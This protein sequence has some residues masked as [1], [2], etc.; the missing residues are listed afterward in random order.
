M[1]VR[2]AVDVVAHLDAA[3]ERQRRER[4]L[5]QAGIANGTHLAAADRA[6][7]IDAIVAQ[8]ARKRGHG[9]TPD[10]VVRCEQTRVEREGWG[11]ELGAVGKVVYDSVELAERAAVALGAA[12]LNDAPLYAY[13]CPRSGTGHAHLTRTPPKRWL[14]RR[15]S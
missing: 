11:S 9:R 12:G 1:A 3:I 10:A 15:S 13:P 6:A 8:F 7:L 2:G 4:A 5:A 14:G